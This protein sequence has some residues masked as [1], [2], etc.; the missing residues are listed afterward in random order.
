[1]Q[2]N[3][4]ALMRPMDL[5]MIQH[6]TQKIS[7]C[8][9]PMSSPGP[10]TSR[11]LLR[12]LMMVSVAHEQHARDPTS[13]LIASQTCVERSVLVVC[14]FPRQP[15]IN[16]L[17]GPNNRECQFDRLFGHSWLAG[18]LGGWLV[19]NRVACWLGWLVNWL[20]VG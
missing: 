14:C 20:L 17:M 4:M 11:S 3:M 7:A 10:T 18:W 9:P 13:A 8:P 5:M 16:P 15:L 12:Q 19:D 2:V 6:Q 1:M